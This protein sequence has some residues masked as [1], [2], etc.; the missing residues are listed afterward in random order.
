MN[1]IFEHEI[2]GKCEVCQKQFPTTADKQ[3]DC[4]VLTTQPL[5]LTGMPQ[6]N[7]EWEFVCRECRRKIGSAV[8]DVIE[9]TRSIAN[10]RSA[11][12]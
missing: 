2:V 6:C 1:K 10:G 7:I 9:N 11:A 4:F 5:V 8:S 12:D 3:G